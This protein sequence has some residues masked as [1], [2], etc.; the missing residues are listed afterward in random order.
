M[1]NFSCF[2]LVAS[3]QRTLAEEG[4]K[5]PILIPAKA[6]PSSLEVRDILGIARTGTGKKAAFALPILNWLGSEPCKSIFKRPFAFILAP[7]CELAIQIG[8][9]LEAHG[10]HLHLRTW[11][12]F[13]G[14]GQGKQVNQLKRG[15]HIL[16]ATLGRLLDLI[17]QKH[18]RLD[19]LEVFVL[20][21]ADRMLDVG[22]LSALKQILRQLP[23]KRQSLFFSATLPPSIESLAEKLLYNPVSVRIKPKSV[24][25]DKIDQR[26]MLFEQGDKQRVLKKLLADDDVDRGIV[27]A[28]TKRGANRLSQH[29]EKNG[30]RAAAIHGNNFQS[31]RQ[32][33][34]AAFRDTKVKVLVAT[35]VATFRA[36]VT[37][38]ILTFRTSPKAMSIAVGELVEPVPT[39]W[40]FRSAFPMRNVNYEPSKN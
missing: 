5:Q 34:L 11:T 29:L 36:L 37:S 31:A 40:P 39:E 18:V 17:S 19:E 24:S 21:E 15:A 35:D 1:K 32:K 26:F 10:R 6:I 16:V 25:V 3:L 27:F 23:E 28:T 20:D 2:E 9:S 13:G 38:L 12:I 7:T 33:A 8:E 14:V 4:H 22:F 30:V